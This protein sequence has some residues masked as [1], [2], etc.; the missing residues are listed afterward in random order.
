[1]IVEPHV[2]FTGMWDFDKDSTST[3][4]GLTTGADDFRV[5]V[6]G[7]L[8]VQAT[9]GVSGRAALSYD[10]IGSDN[11]SAWGGQLWLSVPWN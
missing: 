6:E 4:G 2:A 10:G 3:I 9:N 11:F 5:K 1:M 7:G 8:I